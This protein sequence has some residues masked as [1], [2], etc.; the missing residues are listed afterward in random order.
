MKVCKNFKLGV[1]I[2]FACILFAGSTIA[3]IYEGG[4]IGTTE[5]NQNRV[6]EENASTSKMYTIQISRSAFNPEIIEINQY[7]TV[8][9]RNLNRPKRTFVL[10]SKDK[11]WE[12]YNLAYGRSFA[13]AFNEIGTFDFSIKGE[14]GME[15]TII[16]REQKE[17]TTG[18][19]PVPE[20]EPQ[21]QIQ[22]EEAEKEGNEK[23]TPTPSAEVK[24]PENSV[25][26]LGSAFSPETVELKRGEAIIWKNLNR[27]KRS[28]LLVSEEELFGDMVLG[29]GK[30]F[31]Y[32][33]DKAGTYN[34]RLDNV[35]D[36][37]LVVTVN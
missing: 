36:T 5:K 10:E 16:V 7:D 27:P 6:S 26:I 25:L 34:F 28:F 37:Q 12:D 32:T 15:G 35:S 4:A 11:L 29:Y 18:E 33:F 24:I 23:I 14:K 9:W 30:S 3:A 20:E 1:L 17:V 19:A 31:T 2:V 22:Q 8:V 13:Y 21:P